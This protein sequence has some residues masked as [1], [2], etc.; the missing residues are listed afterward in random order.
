MT[1]PQP[2]PSDVMAARSPSPPTSHPSSETGSSALM[3]VEYSPGLAPPSRQSYPV[4]CPHCKATVPMGVDQLNRS[5][6]CQA[7]LNDF[8]VSFGIQPVQ[9]LMVAKPVEPVDVPVPIAKPIPPTPPPVVLSPPPVVVSPPPPVFNTKISN[10]PPPVEV[11]PPVPKPDEW[12]KVAV[13]AKL[14]HWPP[15]C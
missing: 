13:S 7:C 9:P 8:V 2:A 10:K 14:L 3:V 6:R 1:V 4:P 5:I 11:P 12:T 15:R